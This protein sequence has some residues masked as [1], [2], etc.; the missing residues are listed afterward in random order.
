MKIIL[1]TIRNIISRISSNPLRFIS[2]MSVRNLK[3]ELLPIENTLVRILWGGKK[4]KRG[5]KLKRIESMPS[6]FDQKSFTNKLNFD[7]EILTSIHAPPIPSL[8]E[9]TFF[10]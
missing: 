8:Y 4:K 6:Y 9:N 2:T 5:K 7:K 10:P 1:Y 3:N